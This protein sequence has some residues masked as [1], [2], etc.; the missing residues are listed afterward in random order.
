[1]EL[2]LSFTFYLWYFIFTFVLIFAKETLFVKSLF[3]FLFKSYKN[4]P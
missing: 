4:N 2:C 1:M 3:K